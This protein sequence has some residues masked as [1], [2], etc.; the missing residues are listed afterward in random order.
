MIRAPSLVWESVVTPVEK[1]SH[2]F[3]RVRSL[4]LGLPHRSECQEWCAAVLLTAQNI[5]AEGKAYFNSKT[6]YGWLSLR[7]ASAR[8]PLQLGQS[9]RHHLPFSWMSQLPATRDAAQ[10]MVR[11]RVVEPA[12]APSP[13]DTLHG[14]SG[15]EVAP[16]L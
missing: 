6:T 9:A 14:S 15:R 7:A 5:A 8:A 2:F 10:A 4:A 16:E 11:R 12:R 1:K 13:T 3:V